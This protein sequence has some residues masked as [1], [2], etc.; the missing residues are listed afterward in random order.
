MIACLH[1]GSELGPVD[2]CD[3]LNGK[4]WPSGWP[5]TSALPRNAIVSFLGA[6]LVL[7]VRYDSGVGWFRA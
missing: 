3:S 1:N 4:R 5:L 2:L 6:L 7:L